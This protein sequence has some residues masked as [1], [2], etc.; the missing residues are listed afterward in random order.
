MQSNSVAILMP[1]CMLGR[2]EKGIEPQNHKSIWTKNKMHYPTHLLCWFE[3]YNDRN[4]AFKLVLLKTV[5]C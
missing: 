4:A 5:S 1:Q 2:G 3:V